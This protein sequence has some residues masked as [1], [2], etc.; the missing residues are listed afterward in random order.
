MP[1]SNDVVE[2]LI[3]LR[4]ATTKPADVVIADVVI[5]T[6]A[7]DTEPVAMFNGVAEVSLG[8]I[9]IWSSHKY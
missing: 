2:E 8:Q 5:P 9:E 6:V 3:A 7:T 1:R 4:P